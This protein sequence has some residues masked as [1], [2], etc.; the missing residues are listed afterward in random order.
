MMDA[1]GVTAEF[2]VASIPLLPAA[3]RL[4]ERGIGP[5]GSRVNVRNM[6]VRAEREAGVTD[7]DFLL[8]C[9]AQTSG[10]LLV[11]LPEERAGEYA[12]AC[13]ERGAMEAAIVGRVVPRAGSLIRV[14][15]E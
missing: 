11:A 8:L 1:S 2:R 5:G 6:T 7:E 15:K 14:A 10:G 13:R 4:A 3:R 9:D 12:A